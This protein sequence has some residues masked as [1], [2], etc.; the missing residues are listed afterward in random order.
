MR[1]G[2]NRSAARREPVRYALTLHDRQKRSLYCPNIIST[3]FISKRF[4]APLTTLR[5]DERNTYSPVLMASNNLNPF[6]PGILPPT[7]FSVSQIGTRGGSRSE[8]SLDC[9]LCP[10]AGQRSK[11][12]RCASE[13]SFSY[14]AIGGWPR[15][16]GHETSSVRSG[17]VRRRVPSAPSGTSEPRVGHAPT[18][19]S[20]W[21]APRANDRPGSPRTSEPRVGTI[22]NTAHAF[23]K[24]GAD[25]SAEKTRGPKNA[26]PVLGETKADPL[27]AILHQSPRGHFSG[28]G[29]SRAPPGSFPGPK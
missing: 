12:L 19:R 29:S 17:V 3:T 7:Q 4:T 25:G 10:A 8:E 14:L 2:P 22:H 9:P 15:I 20:S 5:S 26:R 1:L 6:T 18:P 28:C 27:K 16:T 13:V 23:E 21:P 11:P 24:D